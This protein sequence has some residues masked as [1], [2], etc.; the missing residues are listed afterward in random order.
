M[1][2][3][4]LWG[5]STS[6]FQYEGGANEGNKGKSIY[7][8][9]EEKTGIT[10]SLSS[11]FYHRYKEDIALM[12]EMGF[13]SFRMSISWTRLFPLGIEENA[14]KDG[15]NFYKNVFEELRKN[16]IKPIVTL[17]HWDMPQYLIDT[18]D[19]FKSREIVPLFTNYVKTCYQEFG[20]YVDY[21]LTLNENNLSTLLPSMFFKNKISKDDSEYHQLKWES[22]YHSLLCH[23]QAVKLG[24]ELLENT[25]IGCM[26][27]TAY[28][29]PL[30]PKP[31]DVLSAQKHNQETMWDDLDILTTGNFTL[32][33]LKRLENDGVTLNVTKEDTKLMQ[34]P[35]SK[36]DFISFSYYFSLCMQDNENRDNDAE[37]M[38]MLYQSY[39]NPYLEKTDFGWQIDPVG[40]RVIMNELYSRYKLPLMIVENGCGVEI[41]ELTPDFKIHDDY[42]IDYLEKHILEVIKAVEI[43]NLPVMGYL[44]WG[45]IDLY[46]ASGNWKKRYGFV[47]VDFENDLSRYKKDSFYWYK[48]VISTNGETLKKEKSK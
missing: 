3:N 17:F 48:E 30:T 40:L 45:C 19:G 23:F 39:Y 12:K 33:F 42:R 8:I 44:P 35:I 28:A 29:Y 15:I 31:N 9:R 16:D 24:H 47:F 10:Y 38:Q 26:L 6:A 27:A 2:K 18:Y 32:S 7:D 37:T 46:S 41:D 25:Q 13:N 34:S 20:D 36:I 5:G 4:F 11:D 43:D 21:W 14:N 1:K 22:Y